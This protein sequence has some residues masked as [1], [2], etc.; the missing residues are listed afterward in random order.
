MSD[1]S[2]RPFRGIRI[3]DLTT[4]IA[5]PYATKLFV[6]AGAEVIKVEPSAGDPMRRWTASF[7]A[8]GENESAPLFQYLNAGKRS[9]VLDPRD[10]QDRARISRLAER[11]DLVFEE[12]GASVLEE[13][14]LDPEDWL[15]A[16]PRL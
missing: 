13:R 6:D 10:A 5:G 7:Q 12:W 9:I 8:L 16:H 14:G 1:E 2:I 11:S 15:D 4:G 3:L